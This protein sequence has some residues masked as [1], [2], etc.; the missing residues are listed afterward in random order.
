MT[1]ASAASAAVVDFDAFDRVFATQEAGDLTMTHARAVLLGCAHHANRERAWI[2]HRGRFGRA[3]LCPDDHAIR[4]P[5]ELR[6]DVLA[7]VALGSDEAAIRGYALIAPVAEFLVQARMQREASPRKR[8]ERTARA[9]VARQKA[10][11]LARCGRRHLDALDHSH[12]D[13]AARQVI[14]GACANHA[15]AADH[16]MHRKTLTSRDCAAAPPRPRS[17]QIPPPTRSAGRA[18]AARRAIARN[19]NCA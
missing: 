15:A 16:D 6:G 2:D 18:P 12:I 5:F 1:T 8:I 3:Q 14:R 17:S 9:P 7:P 11:S 19:C 13:A 10:A 4:E